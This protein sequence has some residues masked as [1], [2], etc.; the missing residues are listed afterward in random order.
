MTECKKPN[1]KD[2][3][4]IYDFSTSDPNGN[5]INLENYKG[6]VCLIVNICSKDK[7]SEKFL[8]FFSKLNGQFKDKGM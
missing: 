7:S 1:Y 8:K 4:S 5:S 6:K 3:N 2:A